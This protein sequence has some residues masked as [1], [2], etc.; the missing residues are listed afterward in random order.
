M[1]K[2]ILI[3]AGGTGGHIYPAQGFAE[4]LLQL[5]NPPEILF[6]AG[7]LAKNRYFDRSKFPYQE[8]TSSPIISKN[9]LK[10]VRGFYKLVK[11][12]LEAVKIIRKFNPQVV[13]AFGS[14]YTVPVVLAAMLLKIPYIL[15]E[16][17]S[18]PGKAN[19]WLAPY[20]A[21]VGIHFPMTSSLLKGNIV[22]VGMPLRLGFREGRVSKKEALDFYNLK[23][24]M[25][26]LL[27]FGG[28]QGAQ[29]INRLLKQCNLNDLQVIHLIGKEEDMRFLQDHY[30]SQKIKAVVK[31][32]ES[33]MLMAWHAADFFIGRSGASTV[34]EALEFEKP[35]IL[36]PY[37]YATDNHQDI[38]ANFLVDVVCSAVKFR[39]E[40]I[41]P[42]QM[43]ETIQNIDILQMKKNAQIYKLRTN[44]IDL[45]KLVINIANIS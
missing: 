44:R 28:S 4:Q 42:K 5:K 43:V 31:P 32:F 13:V 16:A 11:G 15:H 36:I 33:N 24:G 45:C 1:S 22:E 25:K 41:T 23:E 10:L 20:A 38:N 14:F 21:A 40:S 26:T 39:E 8:I 17:N 29:G 35:G 34:A 12:T 3:A 9:P 18:I 2:K 19:K 6:V 27:V 7:G 37:P 30:H